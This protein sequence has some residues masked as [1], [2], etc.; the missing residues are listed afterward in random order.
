MINIPLSQE[1]ASRPQGIPSHDP[2]LDLVVALSNRGIG[3]PNQQTMNR[4]IVVMTHVMENEYTITQ[5]DVLTR[6]ELEE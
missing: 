5:P 4:L 6:S 2:S 3:I 1:A